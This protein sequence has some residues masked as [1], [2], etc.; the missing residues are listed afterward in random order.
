MSVSPQ[1]DQSILLKKAIEK[2]GTE[3]RY[4]T[5][6]PVNPYTRIRCVLDA[7]LPIVGSLRLTNHVDPVDLLVGKGHVFHV[8][9]RL[10]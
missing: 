4:Q 5:S 10:V 7:G 3:V 1:R 6:V 9:E 2:N 8:E